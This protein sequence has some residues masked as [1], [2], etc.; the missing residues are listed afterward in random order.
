MYKLLRFCFLL[1]VAPLLANASGV[2]D[3]SGF[4]RLVKSHWSEIEAANKKIFYGSPKYNPLDFLTKVKNNCEP[5]YLA[6]LQRS[7]ADAIGYLLTSSGISSADLFQLFVLPCLNACTEATASNVFFVSNPS[8]SMLSQNKGFLLKHLRSIPPTYFSALGLHGHRAKIVMDSLGYTPEKVTRVEYF[9][10]TGD[11]VVRNQIV[12]DIIGAWN[13]EKAK[14]LTMECVSLGDKQ[15]QKALARLWKSDFIKVESNPK[16]RTS[17][18]FDLAKAF[19]T[20]FKDS[21]AHCLPKQA[22]YLYGGMG[23]RTCTDR[24]NPG[25]ST[26]SY[27][28]RWIALT[29]HWELFF[30]KC[31][32]IDVDLVVPDKDAYF[33]DAEEP[34]A[35]GGKCLV[36]ID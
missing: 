28:N 23:L 19:Y 25:R 9:R 2:D 8:P 21:I 26:A 15:I 29:E 17:I 27:K 7:P 11:T 1:I 20:Q 6:T 24:E 5:G 22:Q 30:K 32:D 13:Y 14:S 12:N 35:P 18:R 31:L 4:C 34:S 3:G 16:A 10:I 33:W 36:P